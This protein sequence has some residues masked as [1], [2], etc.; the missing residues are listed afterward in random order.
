[1]KQEEIKYNMNIPVQT[2]SYADK[3]ADDFEWGK[4]TIRAYIQRSYFSATQHKLALKKLYDYYNGH[5]NVEDY[6]LIT[7][8]FGKKLEGDWSDVVNYP[9]IKPKIDLLRGEFAKRPNYK[10]VY[11]TNGDVVNQQLTEKNKIVL[12]NLEQ[13]F[14][15]TL[16]AQGIDSGIPTEEVPTPKEV[17]E[18]FVTSYR[19]KRAILGQRTLEFVEQYCKLKEKHQL[20]FFHWLVT[21]EVYSYRSVEHNEPYYEVVNPLDVDYDKDPDMEFAEDCDWFV[22]RKYM[23][24]SSIVDL[25]YDELGKNEK[26]IKDMI[27][28]IETMGTNTTIFGQNPIIYDSNTPQQIYNRLIEVKHITWRSKVK[29]GI[30]SFIDEFGQPQS[31]EVDETFKPMKELGQEIE[32]FWVNEWWEGFMCGLDT[33]FRIRPIP[34]QRASLDNLSKCKG[35]YNGRQLQ[36][37]NSRNI[38]LVM[39]GV[40]YQILYNA[41]MHRLK[42]AMAKMKDDMIQLDVNLKPK[43]M[44]LEEWMLYGDATGLLFVDYSK[45]GYRGS[46]THQSVLKLASTTIQSY[47]ELLRFVKTEWEE[48]C[49]ISRQREGQ[50]ASSETVGGVERAVIQSSLITEIYFSKFDEYKERDYQAI[51]D[52]AKLAWRDGKK[53]SFVMPDSGKIVYLDVDPIE[54]SEAEYGIFVALSGKQAEKKQKLEMQMQNFIQNGAKASTIVDII[55]S[56]SFVE[57]K[58]KFIYAEQKA[59]E[60][61]Q[62]MEQQKQQAVAQQQEQALA[63]QDAMIDKQHQNAMDLEDLKGEWKMRVA[64]LT[65]YAI[66][67]GDDGSTIQEAMIDAGLR[68]QEL[69][70]KQT[71]IT[72]NQMNDDK[73]MAHE[74]RM[75]DKDMQIKREDIQAKKQIA[76]SKPKPKK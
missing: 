33:Y 48:V 55:N 70:I 12:E 65:A 28:K 64:E 72:A 24:P 1:M 47:I 46:S 49:G 40:P 10:E 56:D 15:N 43:N 31:L 39:L 59:E 52:Y 26:E 74:S 5:V 54:F 7:E 60:L 9:I 13:L 23:T 67:E 44:T 76:K 61:A 42:L 11:V 62:Q 27:N 22:R 71:E 50:I 18:E 35:P 69:S 14:A 68:Q 17:E 53:T 75:K 4:Q 63:A 16:N 34:M 38:S 8:P 3:I 57:L 2:I 29:V 36:A 45:E 19:D 66:D 25:F 30:C 41:T 6:K 32:W 37:T 51:I 20:M 21:G 73:R 58:A